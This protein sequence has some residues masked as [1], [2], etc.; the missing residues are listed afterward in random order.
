MSDPEA[1]VGVTLA[2]QA[3]AFREA[4]RAAWE[5]IVAAFLRALGGPG[6]LG[7]REVECRD[8]AHDRLGL[9]GRV[10]CPYCGAV[11]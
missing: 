6:R 7:V 11:Q 5:E 4:V 10:A 9:C 3:S 2:A 8:G 1:P